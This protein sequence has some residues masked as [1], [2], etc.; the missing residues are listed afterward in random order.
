MKMKETN[1]FVKRGGTQTR[2]RPG[3]GKAAKRSQKSPPRGPRRKNPERGR[4]KRKT[5]KWRQTTKRI[6]IRKELNRRL[7]E[8]LELKKP[9]RKSKN[10]EKKLE[11]PSARGLPGNENK[12]FLT[13][14]EAIHSARMTTDKTTVPRITDERKYFRRTAPLAWQGFAR[15]RLKRP[16][17]LKG[18][19]GAPGVCHRRK[20]GAKIASPSPSGERMPPA[21]A[22]GPPGGR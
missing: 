18:F 17:I 14:G 6:Q 8:L 11:T 1:P 13:H 20:S 15:D 10:K 22:P 3:S 5:K 9:Q 16:L 12:C 2:K 4:G 21:R 7:F 19:S